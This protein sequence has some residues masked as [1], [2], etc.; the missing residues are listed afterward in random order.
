MLYA[1]A[2]CTI[3]AAAQSS[4]ASPSPSPPCR[5]HARVCAACATRAF[6]GARVCAARASPHARDAARDDLR[7]HRTARAPIELRPAPKGGFRR[8]ASAAAP[9]D[10]VDLAT[11][12]LPLRRAERPWLLL[13]MASQRKLVLSPSSGVAPIQPLQPTLSCTLSRELC[14]RSLRPPPPPPSALH[15]IS[16]SKAA[17]CAPS[18][19]RD[20]PLCGTSSL[21]TT[22]PIRSTSLLRRPRGQTS[23]SS[24][25]RQALRRSECPCNALAC[26]ANSRPRMPSTA[27]QVLLALLWAA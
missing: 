26:S 21:A 9:C 15:R 2:C 14:V 12:R 19:A 20:G 27:W 8:R 1:C 18:H 16:S 6:A 10:Q 7:R 4:A 25:G 3:V 23:P 13:C 11:K 17:A 5:Q 22:A 24:R